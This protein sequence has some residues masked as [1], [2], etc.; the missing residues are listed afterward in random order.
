MSQSAVFLTNRMNIMIQVKDK[1]F[2]TY[3]TEVEYNIADDPKKPEW[4]KV[5]LVFSPMKSA[6]K[7]SWVVLLC[8]DAE[9]E[10][11]DILEAYALR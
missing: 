4:M 2:D 11:A 9:M 3:A 10:L 7:S 8:T 1:S 6:P 5:K